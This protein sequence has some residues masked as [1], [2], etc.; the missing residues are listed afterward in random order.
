M[1]HSMAT[2]KTT[3]PIPIGRL[4][5]AAV[6]FTLLAATAT[7]SV[8]PG[9]PEEK[10]SYPAD[11]AQS[12]WI[13]STRTVPTCNRNRVITATP[14]YWRMQTDEDG[15]RRWLP[16]DQDE[17]QAADETGIPTC[18]HIHGNRTNHCEAISEGLGVMKCLEKQADGQPFRMVI[19]SWPSTH[20]QGLNRNDV[21]IKAARSDAQAYYLAR[22]TQRLNPDARVGMIGYSFGARVITGALELLAGGRVAGY[23]LDEQDE[24]PSD[25]SSTASSG[26]PS[27]RIVLIASA[28]DRCWLLPGRRNGSALDLVDWALITR[29]CNDKVLRWYPKMYG[30]SGPQAT[31]FAGPALTSEQREKTEVLNLSCSVGNTHEWQRYLRSSRLYWRL[32]ECIFAESE[33]NASDEKSP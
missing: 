15:C 19:W 18:F 7:A 5:C 14:D 3:R 8:T 29:N 27:I 10:T 11:T 30:F 17:F 9:K 31:G 21:R 23:C 12:V 2:K 6:I 28:T 4:F 33:V 24:T 13:I 32:G 26:L 20:I 25:S 22:C 16:S 1:V